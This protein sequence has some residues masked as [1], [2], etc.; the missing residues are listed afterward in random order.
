MTVHLT[1][2][3][4]N[5]PIFLAPM[6]GVTDFPSR[7]IAQL[8]GPGLVV[9]EMIASS[10]QD[11][12]YF[13][14]TVKSNLSDVNRNKDIS[15]TAIQIAGHEIEWM[16]YAA[17]LIEFEGGDLI[18]INMGCPAKKIVGKFAGSALMKEPSHALRMLES[19][20]KA[21]N[22]P[23]TLKMRLGWDLENINAPLIAKSA[24]NIG[25]QMITIHARTRNQFLDHLLL[26]L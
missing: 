24:E 17:K 13:E 8:F 22:I 26:I 7:Q 19:I 16:K 21:T 12:N 1:N 14:K 15:P 11:K 25:I 5:P 10:E 3:K 23:V 20:V 6:A 18:D 2:L 9:S 4:L